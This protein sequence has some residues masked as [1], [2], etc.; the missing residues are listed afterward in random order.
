LVALRRWAPQRSAHDAHDPHWVERLVGDLDDDAV[1]VVSTRLV[2]DEVIPL[3]LAGLA[4]RGAGLSAALGTE[5]LVFVVLAQDEI[6][7]HVWSVTAGAR[8]LRV[9]RGTPAPP[10][11]EV[12]TTFPAFLQ[13]LA[14]ARSME[15]LAA[16]GR[17]DLSGDPD[18][19]AAVEPYLR[20]DVSPPRPVAS[21]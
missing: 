11:A 8:G 12:R 4:A 1:S 16:A 7:S 15:R 14:G 5:A 17:L 2:A 20:P 13:L 10:R 9:Q 18:L 6:G 3:A 19:L 21:V